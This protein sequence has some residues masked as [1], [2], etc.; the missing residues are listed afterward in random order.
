MS[1]L[2]AVLKKTTTTQRLLAVL[3]AAAFLWAYWPM[4]MAV[5]SRWLK[6]PQYSHG[7][8][9]PL[10][11]GVLLW[12]RR[13]MLEGK[14]LAWSPW[15]LA[16]LGLGLVLFLL[17]GYLYVSWF[18][19]PSLLLTLAGLVLLSGGVPALRRSWPAIAF[20]IFMMPLPY[21]LETALALPLQRVATVTSAYAMQTLGFPAIAENTNIYIRDLPKP[22]EVAPACSGLGMLFS[23][24]TLSCAMVLVI[25]RD[26]IDKT[27]ILVSAIPI[28]IVANI[29]RITL[30]GALYYFSQS[31][32]AK[33][34][35]HDGAGYLMMAVAFA[36]LW[37]ELKIMARLVVPVEAPRPLTFG[38]ALT[39]QL[40]AGPPKEPLPGRLSLGR[41]GK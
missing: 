22:L 32:L 30:T 27:V 6:D 7:F 39:K 5:G 21:R 17:G 23:F 15:G 28:A 19:T 35:F 12:H 38:L 3:L 16:I 24:I 11:S 37:L 25:D 34:V 9:V 41:I 40:P 18:D 26:W 10:F 36:I 31:D 1:E 2:Q 14:R 8:L 29:V 20:L 33:R 4:F 13:T